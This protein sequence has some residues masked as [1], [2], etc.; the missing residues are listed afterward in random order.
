[1][2]QGSTRPSAM[3][4]RGFAIAGGVALSAAC[5][6]PDPASAEAAADCPAEWLQP[7]A[8]DRAIALPDGAGRVLLHAS[9]NGTQSYTCAQTAADGGDH[10]AWTFT[11]P[12]AAL[13][14]CH[15]TAIGHHSASDGVAAAPRWQTS[16][17]AYVVG[18]KIAAWTPDPASIPWLSI[19]VDGTGGSGPLSEARYI[20]RLTTRGGVAPRTACDASQAGASQKVPY[21]ADYFFY[22]P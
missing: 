19:A 4:R 14:D 6:R 9:A 15:A 22:G 20:Q 11:G 2:P 7:P 13:T 17:G 21:T 16:D 8:V 18:R 12:D 10:Y 3:V 1:V 5:H